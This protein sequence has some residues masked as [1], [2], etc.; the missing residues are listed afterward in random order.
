M[1]ENWIEEEDARPSEFLFKKKK[2]KNENAFGP[3]KPGVMGKKGKREWVQKKKEPR[4]TY[5]TLSHYSRLEIA[6][7]PN[8]QGN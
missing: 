6:R 4:A 8:G 7:A 5:K 3:K 2:K 1:K